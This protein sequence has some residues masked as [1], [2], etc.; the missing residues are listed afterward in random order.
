MNN[1]TLRRVYE[2]I[3]T[4]EK[5]QVLHICVCVCVCACVSPGAWAC[6]CACVHVA[7]FIQHATF[8]RHIVMSFVPPPL[9]A[10]YFFTLFHKQ[11][12]FRKKNVVAHKMCNLIFTTNVL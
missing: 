9:A 6:A 8:M 10:P 2:T 3:V 12:N 1:G 5:Q 7:L 11:H 4:V